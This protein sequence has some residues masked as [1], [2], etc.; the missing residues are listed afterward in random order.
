[1]LELQVCM[2]ALS[3]FWFPVRLKDFLELHYLVSTYVEIFPCNCLVLISSLISLWSDY[4]LCMI[5]IWKLLRLDL[6]SRIW[7][8]LV[9]WKENIFFYCRMEYSIDVFLMVLRFDINVLI[10]LFM[11]WMFLLVLCFLVL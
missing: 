2:A 3:F 4:I 9:N 7:S 10:V 1:V 8:S 6:W 11:Y 5:C